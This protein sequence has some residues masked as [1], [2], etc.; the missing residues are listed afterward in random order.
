MIEGDLSY[1]A[2]APRRAAVFEIGSH[3]EAIRVEPV[4]ALARCLRSESKEANRARRVSPAS[5]LDILNVGG[6]A[7]GLG[8]EWRSET[9]TRACGAPTGRRPIVLGARP[10]RGPIRGGRRGRSC[11]RFPGLNRQ[12]LLARRCLPG[13]LGNRARD[14]RVGLRIRPVE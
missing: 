6:F 12:S 8:L 5:P 7:R 10:G 2:A 14:C 1:L 11:A 13:W 9:A 3:V 4:L